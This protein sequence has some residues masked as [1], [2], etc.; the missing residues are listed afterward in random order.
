[1]G[2]PT[3]DVDAC[4]VKRQRLA[5]C[6]PKTNSKAEALLFR[7]TESETL[8]LRLLHQPRMHTLGRMDFHPSLRALDLDWR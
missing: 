5:R 4:L 6:A 7:Y 1:M 3:R 2:N 8:L